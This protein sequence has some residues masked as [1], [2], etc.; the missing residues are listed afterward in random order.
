[1]FK[2]LNPTY[3]FL[4]AAVLAIGGAIWY[5]QTI[6]A[7]ANVGVT[8]SDHIKGNPEATVTLVEYSDFQCPACGQ[9]EPIVSE[10]VEQNQANLRFEYKHFPLL[11]IHPNAV[12][13]ARAAEAAAQQGKF[14]EMHDALF[15][16]QAT[17]SGA[18][19]PT[20]YFEQYAKES[21]LDLTQYQRQYKSSLIATKIKDS[22]EA[23]QELGL[24]G[25]PS[26]FLNGTKM[27]F[28]TIA[29]FK[30]QIEAALGITASTSVE[31]LT[32]NI[33]FGI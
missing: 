24:R 28:E 30:S 33:Q 20:T 17:W 13:A 1:M 10:L 8:F 15:T 21:G 25:T 4:A 19:N 16:N 12:P 9:F 6:S 23:G 26:F 27:E 11:T 14:W 2:K 5:A 3:I 29:D 22:F 31:T 7:K 18:S 32:P